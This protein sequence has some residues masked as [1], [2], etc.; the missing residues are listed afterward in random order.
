MIST[1]PESLFNIAH[2]HRFKWRCLTPPFSR[3]AI[4]IARNH[5]DRDY[6]KRR[7]QRKSTIQ[8]F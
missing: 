4:W 3:A 1:I 2:I 7:D 6:K 8:R 5:D